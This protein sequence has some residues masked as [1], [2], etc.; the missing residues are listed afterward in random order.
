[1]ET[2]SPQLLASF[3]RVLFGRGHPD[4]LDQVDKAFLDAMAPVVLRWV[5]RY[6]R[7]TFEGL[8][9]VPAGPA[10]VV[11]NHEA[12]ITWL[13]ALAMGALLRE[14]FPGEPLHALAHD[15]MF[16][17]PPLKGFLVS[18]GAV[19]ATPANALQLLRQGGK[20]LVAPGGD[21][22]AFRPYS[23]RYQVTLGGRKGF[24]K[25]AM[26]AGVPICPVVFTGGHE[27]FVV[28]T[29]G[30]KLSKALRLKSVF[31]TDVMPLY[32][33]LPWGLGLGFM[34]H[35]PLPSRSTVD[36]LDPIGPAEFGGSL[37]AAD[38]EAVS[39]LFDA[40]VGKMQACMDQTSAR[41][42]WPVLG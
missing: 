37:A 34:P 32:A 19:R 26:E 4:R 6:F 5:S 2:I 18:C 31:R 23:K 1:M 16:W 17:F 28:L 33:G 14:K 38:P 10:L 12:G 11:L 13:Q 30:E 27:S 9:R 3:A 36:F 29:S 40:V 21:K 22:E 42:K 20:V 8:E 39:S 25:V 7:M 41:R 15:M 35:L 24:V